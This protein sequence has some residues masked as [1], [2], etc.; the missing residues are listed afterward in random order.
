MGAKLNLFGFYTLGYANGN[1]GSPMNPYDVAED[2]GRAGYDV[3]HRVFLGGTWTV[4]HGFAISPFVVA[5]SGA[6]FNITLNKVDLYGTANY[7]DRPTLASPGASGSNIVV[8]RWGT[9][10]T[11]PGPNSAIIGPN[12]GTGPGQFTANLRLSKTVGLGK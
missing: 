3:R 8:T 7:N 4:P 10:N 6:P 12:F 5:N 9:F 11:V 1:T 2:Y